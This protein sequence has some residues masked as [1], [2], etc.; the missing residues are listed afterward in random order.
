MLLEIPTQTLKERLACYKIMVV[1]LETTSKFFSELG[2]VT[3][4]CTLMWGGLLV[5]K[6]INWEVII[7]Y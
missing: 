3:R 6:D 5:R 7:I 4:E 2:I 1:P